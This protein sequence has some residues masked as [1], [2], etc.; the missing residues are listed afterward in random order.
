[1]REMSSVSVQSV[2][3]SFLFTSP[4]FPSPFPPHPLPHLLFSFPAASGLMETRGM[5][6]ALLNSWLTL[7]VYRDTMLLNRLV[8]GEGEEGEGR[9]AGG[10]SEGERE[11][12]RGRE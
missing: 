5:T 11:G 4:P 9:G 8:W 1:M 3:L 12:G 7:P 2:S 6:R 10:G